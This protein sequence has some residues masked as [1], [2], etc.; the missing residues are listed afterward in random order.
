MTF[1]EKLSGVLSKG[2]EV[3]RKFAK[4]A[5][6]ETNELAA[7]GALKIE[8]AQMKSHA[9]KLLAKLGGEVYSKLV[10]M[11]E[12]SINRQN[13]LIDGILIEIKALRSKIEHKEK[14]YRSI[15]VKAAVKA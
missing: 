10:D 1:T 12:T 15:G 13:P 3:T 11:K 5:G 7:K 14:E 2:F 8:T 6:K 9:D 4:K